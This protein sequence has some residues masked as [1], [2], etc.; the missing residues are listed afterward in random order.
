MNEV[1]IRPT[2]D[3]FKAMFRCNLEESTSA[4]VQLTMQPDMLTNIVEYMY[5]CEIELT[6]DKV[7]SL[8]KAGDLLQLVTSTSGVMVSSSR[9]QVITSRQCS[10]VTLKKERQPQSS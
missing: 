10:G 1:A 8:V 7:E 3:Y 5:T 6:V 9:P 4:T 2:V